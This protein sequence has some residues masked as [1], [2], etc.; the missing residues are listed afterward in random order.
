MAR[1]KWHGE[2]QMGW[3]KAKYKQDGTASGKGTANIMERQIKMQ[4]QKARHGTAN[5]KGTANKNG[6][7]NGK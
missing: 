5:G 7:A 2:I 1:Y 6:T 4:R 3:Q